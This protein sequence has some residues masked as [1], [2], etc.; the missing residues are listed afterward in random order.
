MKAR[1]SYFKITLNFF[2][3]IIF[4]KCFLQSC[5]YLKLLRHKDFNFMF[6]HLQNKRVTKRIHIWFLN[7]LGCHITSQQEM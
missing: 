6:D 1:L 5:L 3:F 2:C 7:G 4:I